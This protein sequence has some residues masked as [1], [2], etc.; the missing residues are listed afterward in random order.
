MEQKNIWTV[1]KSTASR[2]IT[3]RRLGFV[4]N[5]FDTF[6]KGMAKPFNTFEKGM[7]KPFMG[8]G[9]SKPFIIKGIKQI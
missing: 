1:L 5:T 7:A 2:L 4:N 6:E 8:K 9:T 3:G